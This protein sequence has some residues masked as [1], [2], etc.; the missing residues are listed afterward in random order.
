MALM[1]FSHVSKYSATLR[2]FSV[3][4]GRHHQAYPR[5]TRPA[6]AQKTIVLDL[7]GISSEAKMRKQLAIETQPEVVD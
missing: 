5:K 3:A 6:Q 4:P 1:A 2:K 7:G